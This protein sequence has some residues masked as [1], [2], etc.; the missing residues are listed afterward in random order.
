MADGLIYLDY[1]AT[2][3]LDPRVRA[4]MDAY[5]DDGAANPHSATHAPG[6][7]AA[8]AVEQARRQVAALIGAKPE[9]IVF[10]SGG[11]EANNL[12]ILGSAATG[13]HVLTCAIEHPCVLGACRHLET[14]GTAVT[15]LPVD[16]DGLIEPGVVAEAIREDT[17]LVSIML[18]NNEIGTIQPI[19]EI[20]EICRARGVPLHS[21]VAQAAGKLSIDVQDFGVDLMT[22]S[23]HKLHGP[24]GIG[25]LYL[26][27]GTTLEP[28]LFGGA[29]ERGLRPGT[30]P[31]PLA[32][33]FGAAAELAVSELTA[34]AEQV[35]D[36]RERLWTGLR[37]R[38]PE[39][40]ANGTLDQRLP[41]NLNL[42]C[43]GIDAEDWLLASP[44]LALS[45]G[46]ACASGSQEPSHVLRA[47]GLSPEDIRAS[48][49]IGIGRFTTRAEIERTI[50]LLVVG[51]AQVRAGAASASQ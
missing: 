20:A 6:W 5:L 33:G 31:A 32:V 8:E 34:E 39:I 37:E 45:S 27:G 49:R 38:I 13:G 42:R 23:A 17:R 2:T 9:E 10:T 50:D 15:V 47:I 12:A 46:A 36:L 21:D 18:A 22:I 25:A 41:G 4:A 44:D 26:R 14:Q 48:I 3:P 35:R 30:V 1:H 51:L 24:M 11:T 16:C 7:R 19:Q 43:P 28:I 40:I 29:Q